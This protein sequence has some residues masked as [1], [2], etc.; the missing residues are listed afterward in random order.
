MAVAF[1]LFVVIVCYHCYE[2]MLKK[3]PVLQRQQNALRLRKRIPRVRK[4]EKFEM[5]EKTT[6]KPGKTRTD[7]I[8]TLMEL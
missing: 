5:E 1:I 7:M 8:C 2:Y 3:I 6:K 4:L